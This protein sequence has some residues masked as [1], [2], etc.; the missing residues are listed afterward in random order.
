[1]KLGLHIGP[2]ILLF[3][4]V[5]LNGAPGWKAVLCAFDPVRSHQ[6][7]KKKLLTASVLLA[8]TH[9]KSGHADVNHEHWEALKHIRKE[10][11]GYEEPYC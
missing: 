2:F 1:M 4:W 8:E 9:L 10:N 6:A 11:L 7:L 5:F 3:P